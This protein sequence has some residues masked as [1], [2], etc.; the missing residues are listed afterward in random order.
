MLRGEQ[1]DS[2]AQNLTTALARA[3]AACYSPDLSWG[4]YLYDPATS[5]LSLRDKVNKTARSLSKYIKCTI[6]LA[7]LLDQAGLHA[8][9][10]GYLPCLPIPLPPP[11]L[12]PD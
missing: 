8:T 2:Q 12:T 1:R 5:D 3:W 10:Q 4:Y 7:W 9:P 6:I 11:R